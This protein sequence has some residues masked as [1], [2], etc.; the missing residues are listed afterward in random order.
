MK[1]GLMRG[2]A[3]LTASLCAVSLVAASYAP[4]RSAFIN[5]RL[6]TVSYRLEETGETTGDSYYFESEFNSLSDLLAAKTQLAEQISAE[7]TVLL[8]N[9][10]ALPLDASTEPV[11]LWGHNSVFTARGG[12]IG[13]TAA[14]GEGQED[15]NLID[16]MFARGFQ[17]NEQMIGLLT[18]EEAFAY[19]R[20]TFFPGAGLVPSFEAT[21][22]QPAVY[23]VGEIPASMYT[24]DVLASADGTAAVCVITRDSSEAADYEP[25]MFNGT[26]G[27][28]FERP[29]ALSQYEKDMIELAKQHST[30][31][32]VLINADNPLELEELKNDDEID[33]I[34]WAGEPGVYGFLGVADVLSGAAN[35]SGHLPD[36]YA[37]NSAS[38]PAMQNFGLYLYSNNSNSGAASGDVAQ[39]TTDNKSDWYVVE[40]EGIYQ[41]YKYY[42][43]RYEDQ[44]LGQGNAAAAEGSSNGGAWSYANEVS[45]PFGYGASY[46]TFEQKLDSV[47]VTA[48]Q[49]GSAK[50]TVTN[51]GNVAGKS[52]VELYV[53]TPY[54]NGGL[55]KSAVQLVGFAKTSE[56]APGASETVTVE[57]DPA[58]FASYDETVTKADGT[59]GAWVLE[60]GDYYFAI[61]NGVHN[62]LNN[63]LAKKTGSTDNLISVNEGEQ[64]SADNAVVWNLAG[65]DTETYSVNV[66]NAI[67]NADINKL[68]PG[69]AEYTTRA[70]WSKGWKTVDSITPTAD[71][72]VGLTN[73]TYSLSENGEGVTWGADNGLMLV[74]ML[75]TDE[76]GNFSGVV[77]FEDPM[78]D[79]LVQQITLDEAIHFIEWGADDIENID[80][81][82]LPRTYMNDGPLGFAYDQIAGY[83]TRWTSADSSNPYYVDSKTPESKYSMATMPTEPVVAATW[84]VDLIRR[85]AELYGE[86]ALRA[87]ESIC[88]APGANLHR[89]PY[90]ARNHEYY[91]EDPVLT[92]L[93]ATNFCEGAASKGLVTQVKHYAFNHQELNRSGISTFMTEQAARENEL[94]CFQKVMS[95]NATG[96]IMTAFN[97]IGTT[98]VGAYSGVLEQIGRKEWG[99]KGG[100]VTDLVNGS[101]YMNWLDTVSGGGGIM[102]GSAPNWEGT[103]L[104]IMEDSKKEIAKDTVFQQQMQYTLKTWL[105]ATAQS[106]VLNGISNSTKI[107]KV[108]PWW[109]ASIYAAAGVTA[110]LT[111]IFLFLGFKAGKKEA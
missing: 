48:G 57:I 36:T 104:G 67:Q 77:D 82:L 88:I 58:L 3:A 10:G 73:S 18:S 7:G 92:S 111:A 69:T 12:M 81:V 50:V 66:Q 102:L 14:A 31:V 45:Y 56:L 79:Q 38:A 63:I 47:D 2:L 5:A 89:T 11:T 19:T 35:P 78:W 71:M 39:L 86:D 109:L 105:Y 75:Q 1:Q 13:S 40:T 28:S 97:R 93:M 33:A 103:K 99:Y 4:T 27:D 52:V 29:L 110:V 64:I 16:A 23:L 6:G 41:G 83:G 85:E 21:W 51:T 49:V 9:N 8:K 37:V 15:V 34:V 55:E 54:T 107:V 62:A 22:E 91:S 30:K 70:D 90:C 72:M 61:G 53:Q 65:A 100:Y 25:T 87:K 84:N 43:T 24:D 32:I 60:A 96:T 101:M 80:S 95:T 20:Q 74:N 76:N 108:T 26:E 98:Y 106:N 46:T 68:I 42:E 59:V 17:L 94:R 44:V